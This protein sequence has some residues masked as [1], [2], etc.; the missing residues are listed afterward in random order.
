MPPGQ[1]RPPLIRRVAA[2]LVTGPAAFL[3][4]G[5]LDWAALLG[6]W[7]AARMRGGRA[8]WYLD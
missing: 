3:V 6:R 2:R 5:V 7:L 8:D 4:A 1:P